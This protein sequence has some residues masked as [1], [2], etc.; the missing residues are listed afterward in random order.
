MARGT[1]ENDDI[2]TSD[3]IG[4]V[5][6]ILFLSMIPTATGLGTIGLVILDEG[7]IEKRVAVLGT[8][9]R[10]M[11]MLDLMRYHAQ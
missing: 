4:T 5:T 9:D 7:N 10:E 6:T 8:T 1:N 3:E 2:T 11:L